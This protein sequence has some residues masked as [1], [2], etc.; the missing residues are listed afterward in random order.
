M[1]RCSEY[2]PVSDTIF[3]RLRALLGTGVERDP[4]GVPR[5]TPDSSDALSLVCRLA[6]EEGWK[7]RIEGMGTWL[8]PDAPADLV[9]STRGLDQVVS[10]SPADL[11][12]AALPTTK[13]GW[14]S[15]L[16]VALSGR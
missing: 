8:P 9:V 11:V 1:D 2:P 12:A 13:C 10:V 4:H 5:A 7:I 15:I 3:T 16:R 6:H 14:P